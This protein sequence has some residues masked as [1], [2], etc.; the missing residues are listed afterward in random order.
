MADLEKTVQIVFAG[1]N[2]LSKVLNAVNSDMSTLGSSLSDVTAPLASM[3]AAALK[4][5]VALSC[6]SSFIRFTYLKSLRTCYHTIG[7]T[8]HAA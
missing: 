7:I 2:N 4:A 6:R 5:E 1:T 8:I 3:S